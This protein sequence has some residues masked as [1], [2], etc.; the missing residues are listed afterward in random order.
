MDINKI[1]DSFLFDGTLR[2]IRPFGAGHIN[3]TYIADYTDKEYVLQEINTYVFK[4]PD[5]LMDNI[6][7]VT[8]FLRRKIEES[9]GDPERETL[10]FIHTKDKKRYLT[11]E[12][13]E[14]WRAYRFLENSVCYDA[15]DTPELFE[16]S[17]A[18][19]GRFQ[20]ML[21]DYNAESLFETI[22]HF[23]NTAWRYENEFLPALSNAPEELRENCGAEIDFITSKRHYMSVISDLINEGIIPLRVTHNDTK[24]NNVL[25]DEQTDRALAVIDLDTVMPGSALYDFGDAIRYGANPADEDERDLSKVYLDLDYFKAYARGYLSEA[26]LT[27]A[28]TD[29]LAMSALVM[30]LE[31]AMRFLT[32]YLNGNKYFKYD[33]PEHNLVRTRAQLKLALDIEKKL[34]VM[35]R[36]VAELI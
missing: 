32:D 23:H 31:L 7:N 27:E 22:P 35:N 16:K 12:D 3:N 13:G 28:E 26:E 21:K 9:E 6:I 1:A 20:K 25:F 4:Q 15:A 34:D 30:T 36:I 24:L 2:D 14:V 10:H 33:Y 29:K 17:G 18:A 19:F 11:T 5:K 8:R